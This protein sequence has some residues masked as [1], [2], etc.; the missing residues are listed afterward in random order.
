MHYF[1]PHAPY[2]LRPRFASPQSSGHSGLGAGARNN[3]MAER[4]KRYDSEIG[5]TDYYLG[6]LLDRIDR[7]GLRD[8]TVVVLTSDHGESLGEHGYVG[9]GSRLDEGILRVPL[10][11]R[12]PKKIAQGTVI[13]E[14]VSLLD[15]A[16]TV[17]D[18]AKVSE[19]A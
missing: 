10:I 1:D 8:S 12:Y 7:L 13:R 2:D 19:I 4:I 9:H 11:V 18:L 14:P 5:Y 17:L 16:P 6:R 3:E 15:V